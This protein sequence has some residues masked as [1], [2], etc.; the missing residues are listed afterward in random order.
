[1]VITSWHITSRKR[2]GMPLTS[3]KRGLSIPYTRHQKIRRHATYRHHTNLH[4]SRVIQATHFHFVR[5]YE[6]VKIHQGESNEFILVLE[7]GYSDSL[8][9]P[10]GSG[11]SQQREKGA[12]YKNIERKMTLKKRRVNVS[13][14]RFF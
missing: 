5:D 6:A 4:V 9:K 3:K 2:M 13:N 11:E 1:M 10:L 8:V 7:D 14:Y 12:Y